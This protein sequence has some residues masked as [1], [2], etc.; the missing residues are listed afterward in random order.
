MRAWEYKKNLHLT[1]TSLI[2]QVYTWGNASYTATTESEE[3]GMVR[4]ETPSRGSR[5]F[6]LLVYCS[7]LSFSVARFKIQL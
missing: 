3:R 2:H 1:G 4:Y 7:L 6:A 5:S